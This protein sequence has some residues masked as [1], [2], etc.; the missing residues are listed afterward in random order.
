MTTGSWS[1]KRRIV[2]GGIFIFIFAILAGLFYWQALYIAPTCSDGRK[3]GGEVGIDCGGKCPNLCTSDTLNPAVLWSK[4]FNVSGDVYTAV[5]YIEN[6]NVNSKNLKAEYEFTIFDENGEVVIVKNG[7]T[8]IPRGKKFAVFETGLIFKDKK[9]KTADFR[10][11]KYGPWQKDTDTS[12]DSKIS[13][14]HT[15][16]VSTSTVPRVSGTISNDS[17]ET[18]ASLEL[19]VFVLD[20]NENVVAASNTFIDNLAKRSTQD[21]VFTWP[22]PFNLGVE[23]CTSP[24]DISLAIDKSGSMLSE[25]K[26]PPEPFSTVIATANDF[27]KNLKSGDQA[28]IISFGTKSKIESP[29]SINK[30]ASSA[31]VLGIVLSTTTLEQTNITG[32]LSDSFSELQSES[33]HSD[34]K[35]VV[36]LLTD[37]I[38]TEPI[39]VN[40]KDYPASSAKSIASIIKA[41]G[42]D[43]YTIGLGKDVDEN[44]L[45]SIATDD[46]HYFFAPSKDVLGRIYSN[47]SSKLCAKRPNVINVIYRELK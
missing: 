17:L 33:A 16:L 1:T 10:F 26:N 36:I 7:E 21:F 4:V 32:G 45:R 47:I 46:S 28:S 9:P 14:K 31:A 39:D 29:L 6:P 40:D 13:I 3:N 42:I 2:I 12:I 27:I 34:S 24:L 20:G 35:K 18:I 37:G 43:I 41:Q 30:Q 25:G 8:S 22:R 19:A 38:P 23:T 44:F 5:S 11:I 15:S